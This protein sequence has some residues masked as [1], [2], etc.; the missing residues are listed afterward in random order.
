MGSCSSRAATAA[1]Y[2]RVETKNAKKQL[3]FARQLVADLQGGPKNCPFF[4]RLNFVRFN[5]IK[6]RFSNLFHCLNQENICN[7]SIT[8]DPSH[9]KYVAT[10]PCEMLVS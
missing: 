7:N 9:L 4:V 10:L 8:K 1:F 6:D 5:F 3:L 2:C